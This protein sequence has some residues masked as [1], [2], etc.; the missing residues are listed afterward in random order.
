MMELLH[1]KFEKITWTIDCHASFEALKKALTEASILR[2]MDPLKGGLDLCMEA[3]DMAIVV[4][5]L[6][7]GMV[8]AYSSKKLNYLVHI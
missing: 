2:I 5:L 8:I 4:I 6:Q 1:D 3:I 7:E